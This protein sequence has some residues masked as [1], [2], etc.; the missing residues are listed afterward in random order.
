M[1]DK[2]DGNW[3]FVLGLV[4]GIFLYKIIFDM[5]LPNFIK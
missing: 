4:F 1:E 2:K 3:K 5:I